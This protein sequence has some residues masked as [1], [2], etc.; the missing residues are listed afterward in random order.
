VVDPDAGFD[1]T[2]YQAPPSGPVLAAGTLAYSK[3]GSVWTV[4]TSGGT[5]GGLAVINRATGYSAYGPVAASPTSILYLFTNVPVGDNAFGSVVGTGG[6]TLGAG[7]DVVATAQPPSPSGAF[8]VD[9]CAIYFVTSGGIAKVLTTMNMF[10]EE[11]ATA[12]NTPNQLAQDDSF[13]YWTDRDSVRVA[14]K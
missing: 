6:N 8:V 4:S 2:N 1:T 14:A 11:I 10:P 5:L 7:D 12:P 13:V 9:S 3:D